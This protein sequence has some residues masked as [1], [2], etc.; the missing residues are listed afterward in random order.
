MTCSGLNHRSCSGEGGAKTVTRRGLGC[1]L[2]TLAFALTASV[3]LMTG[4][5]ARAEE[6]VIAVSFPNYSKQG[7]VITTL[8][9][10]TTKGAEL[11]YKVV[12]DDPGTDLN[13][14]VNTINTWIQRKV[15]VIIAVVLEP[16][17]FEGVAKRAREAGVKWITYAGKIEN[18]DAT[19]GFSHYDNGFTLG[20]YAGKWMKEN[21]DKE[22]QII[23][24]GYEKGAWGQERAKGIREG[25]KSIVPDANIVAEQDAISPAEGLNTTRTLLQAHPDANIILGIE[26]PATEGAYKAWVASGRDKSDPKAF[27]GGM[28]GTVEALKLLREGGTVYRA[29]MAIPLKKLGDAMVELSVDLINGKTPGDRMVP[30]ELVTDKSPL[31]DAYLK[32]QGVTD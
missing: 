21:P 18:Q 32:E 7:S 29:S 4:G 28:D 12:L 27:I 15:P 3:S 26:D 24:L 16:T 5:D 2:A 31:A 14:Q 9:Q 17:V 19:V 13:K 11:G 6:K 8:D 25:L 1:Q 30:M 10:A 23:L 22:H 20:E